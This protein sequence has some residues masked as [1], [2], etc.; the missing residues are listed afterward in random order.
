M[1]GATSGLAPAKEQAT[2]EYLLV[3][4]CR[5]PLPS[6]PRFETVYENQ[7]VHRVISAMVGPAG[8]LS[9]FESI[10]LS[11][12]LF[13]NIAAMGYTITINFQLLLSY[14]SRRS[15]NISYDAYAPMMTSVASL[16]EIR[17]TADFIESL[18]TFVPLI[19]YWSVASLNVNRGPLL[20]QRREAAA[21]RGCVWSC[22]SCLGVLVPCMAQMWWI[23]PT[24]E[25]AGDFGIEL[26]FGDE[27]YLWTVEMNGPVAVRSNGSAVRA[28]PLGPLGKTAG[29]AILSRNRLLQGSTGGSILGAAM[30]LC[31][32][33][34]AS[35]LF[36]LLNLLQRPWACRASG[37]SSKQFDI[38][39]DLILLYDPETR[40]HLS[41]LAFLVGK[42]L[43]KRCFFRSSHPLGTLLEAFSGSSSICKKEANN[44]FSAASRLAQD[45][46]CGNNA[47]DGALQRN[48]A[49]TNWDETR[50]KISYC[51][52]L[53]LFL[54]FHGGS[55]GSKILEKTLG[56]LTC[57][58]EAMEMKPH[59]RSVCVTYSN[60]EFGW[61]EIE[62]DVGRETGGEYTHSHTKFTLNLTLTLAPNLTLYHSSYSHPYFSVS[63]L[64][65]SNRGC[66]SASDYLVTLFF[67][68]PVERYE[69]KLSQ[70]TKAGT[71][72][73]TILFENQVQGIAE[74]DRDVV[75]PRHCPALTALLFVGFASSRM[76][77]DYDW[78]IPYP[79]GPNVI[80]TGLPV[81][82]STEDV[83]NGT[84][85]LAWLA[86]AFVALPEQ[87]AGARWCCDFSPGWAD[88][89]SSPPTNPKLPQAGG[90]A[91]SRA[92]V[93]VKVGLN[94]GKA[95][96]VYRFPSRLSRSALD[97]GCSQDMGGE[98]GASVAK[99][100]PVAYLAKIAPFH[101]FPSLAWAPAKLQPTST[102]CCPV[103]ASL[104][105][106]NGGKKP[107]GPPSSMSLMK[108]NTYRLCWALST[109]VERDLIAHDSATEVKST[110]CPI[111][112]FSS[113]ILADQEA[114]LPQEPEGSQ[115]NR[116]A[117]VKLHDSLSVRGKLP[118]NRI[119]G[120]EERK[121]GAAWGVREKAGSLSLANYLAQC[122]NFFC[123]LCLFRQGASTNDNGGTEERDDV[124]GKV[125]RK[126]FPIP[127][128]VS[129]PAPRWPSGQ[130]EA[131]LAYFGYKEANGKNRTFYAFSSTFSEHP[132]PDEEQWSHSNR[133]ICNILR[134]TLSV[135]FASG[136]SISAGVSGWAE[137][138]VEGCARRVIDVAQTAWTSSTPVA[139]FS[140][141]S[142]RRIGYGPF[143]CLAYSCSSPPFSFVFL[144]LRGPHHQ[145][146]PQ[147]AFQTSP[148]LASLRANR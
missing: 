134:G 12:T 9:K 67:Q 111:G 11:S 72:L 65:I 82:K 131:W 48:L 107:A 46:S 147:P 85:S 135:V 76:V 94:G 62:V 92:T 100:T 41:P 57:R 8:G 89:L 34:P 79:D 139:S 55:G 29:V 142:H 17:D 30:D 71:A 68:M 75:K 87:I 1:R 88:I 74:P 38:Q 23:G 22:F 45:C 56:R 18:E 108:M 35:P 2:A 32:W 61:D 102:V 133:P 28:A 25:T 5:S 106:E 117:L 143:T 14:F 145:S 6:A 90:A 83:D 42:F 119:A 127:F 95:Y 26:A 110:R 63:A 27:E 104:G 52:R 101:W 103:S 37:A 60:T 113:T 40:L 81:A 138:E 105:N 137:K 126:L 15:A 47:R 130:E 112:L 54:H 70:A 77:W 59:R 115:I 97:G 33:T 31:A 148:R 13:G 96:L 109:P 51:V 16:V 80:G 99:I 69:R 122:P 84:C 123:F 66:P 21:K 124:E 93:R 146:C 125:H 58:S 50:P 39:G 24:V 53:P 144:P 98:T 91:S 73:E 49:P 118:R 116:S 78:A 136:A 36:P 114:G 44:T 7:T 3:H 43:S 20:G 141:T 140:T 120:D 132:L 64:T 4:L 129:S 19:R 86:E 128:P 10:V 121:R